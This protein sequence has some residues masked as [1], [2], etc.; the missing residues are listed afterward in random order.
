MLLYWGSHRINLNQNHDEC[1]NHPR[2][3]HKSFKPNPSPQPPETILPKFP[4]THPRVQ[5]EQSFL[6]QTMLQIHPDFMWTCKLPPLFYLKLCSYQE[7]VAMIFTLWSS[8]RTSREQYMQLKH[9][10]FCQKAAVHHLTVCPWIKKD[11]KHGV[12][13]CQ[14][15][16]AAIKPK[17]SQLSIATQL[18]L[19]YSYRCNWY[20]CVI[21]HP[22]PCKRIWGTGALTCGFTFF[23]LLKRWICSESESQAW[24]LCL[25]CTTGIKATN[26]SPS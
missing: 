16:L 17:L 6:N 13:L 21:N 9:Q 12:L 19:H 18:K 23:Q 14:A 26:V 22:C 2:K 15:V 4:C 7:S 8:C 10:S 24:K 5:P 3:S 1:K 25:I 11:G 20:S